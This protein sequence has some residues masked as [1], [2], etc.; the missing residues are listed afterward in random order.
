MQQPRVGIIKKNLNL[1][2]WVLSQ[3][4]HGVRLEWLHGCNFEES[5]YILLQVLIIFS[6][7]FK[8]SD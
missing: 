3:P 5:M 1:Q 6:F 4:G 7:T 2:N 8:C